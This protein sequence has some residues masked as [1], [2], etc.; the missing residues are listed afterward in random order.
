MKTAGLLV[1]KGLGIGAG[2]VFMAL[3]L[4]ASGL[5]VMRLSGYHFLTVA[6]GSMQPLLQPGDLII[7]RPVHGFPKVGEVVSYSSLTS[8]ELITHRV[9]TADIERGLLV[10]KGDNTQYADAPIRARQ[11]VGSMRWRL[12]GIGHWVDKLRQ[13]RGLVLM[14]YLPG[15][16]VVVTALWR[17]AYQ[18]RRQRR[19]YHGQAVRT[20]QL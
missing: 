5:I 2:L 3:V 15:C 18:Y 8:G 16:I 13:P 12:Q 17:L 14:V 9:Q 10:T 6:S 7:T 1:R 20:H 4:A 11:V 19:Y